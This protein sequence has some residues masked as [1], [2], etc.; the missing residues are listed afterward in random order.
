MAENAISQILDHTAGITSKNADTDWLGSDFAPSRGGLAMR[1]AVVL[2]T[3]R[4]IKAVDD[5]DTVIGLNGGALLAVNQLYVFDLPM[6]K[7]RTYNL[8]NV[9]GAAAIDYLLMWEVP[10]DRL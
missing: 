9:G 6:G 10:G 2:A 3:S 1:I 4:A 8:Q 5:T 7:D